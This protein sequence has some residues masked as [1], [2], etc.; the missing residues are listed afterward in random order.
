MPPSCASRAPSRGPMPSP[1]N[2][3]LPPR[4]TVTH[5]KRCR[6][7]PPHCCIVLGSTVSQLLALHRPDMFSCCRRAP[8]HRHIMHPLARCR[9]PLPLSACPLAYHF[10]P[11][12]FALACPLSAIVCPRARPCMPAGGLSCAAPCPLVC[13]RALPL[14]PSR[15]LS[16]AIARPCPLSPADYMQCSTLLWC[17]PF[18]CHDLLMLTICLVGVSF[19]GDYNIAGIFS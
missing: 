16:L 17:Y 11:L 14:S 19:V 5:L 8:P 13:C 1:R 9:M 10:T 18:S 15:T 7:T 3:A 4:A 6:L 12:S 2:P